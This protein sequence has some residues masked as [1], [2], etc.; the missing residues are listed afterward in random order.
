MV[1][2]M[3]V[4]CTTCPASTTVPLNGI[5]FAE[6]GIRAGGWAIQH[7]KEMREKGSACEVDRLLFTCTCGDTFTEFTRTASLHQETMHKMVVNLM[8]W[9]YQHRPCEGD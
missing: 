8:F 5:T 6:V 4:S 1:A 3:K 7:I 2:L 9:V